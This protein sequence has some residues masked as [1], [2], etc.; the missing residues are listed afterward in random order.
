MQ[1]YLPLL[2]DLL[3]FLIICPLAAVA[4]FVDAVAGGGGL[5]SLPAYLI[6]GVPPHL[7]LGTNKLMSTL[8]TSVATYRYIKA[9][10]VN[11]SI[12]LCCIPFA[13]IGSALGS[14]LALL[15]DAVYLKMMLLVLLPISAIFLSRKH[16]LKDG[17]GSPSKKRM[18]IAGALSAL[19][20][21]VYDGFYGPGTGVFLILALTMLAK[22]KLTDAN[23]LTK[24]INLSTNVA[25]LVVFL[26]H[27]SVLLPLGLAAAFFNIIGN[28]LG[29]G[30]FKSK[31]AGGCRVIM[32]FVIVIFMARVIWDLLQ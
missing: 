20:V 18:I 26:W 28:Y 14:S 1:D 13:F 27:G 19:I 6:A 5:I 30:F 29:S 25:A 17:D 10:Y 7:A 4:G 31:G 8:G 23:G 2:N 9:G 21:G 15:V 3:P 12:A 32:L 24:M 16:A 22:M 11:F